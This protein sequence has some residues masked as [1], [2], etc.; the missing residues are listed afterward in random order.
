MYKGDKENFG[1][2]QLA[3]MEKRKNRSYIK[4]PD[5][6]KDNLQIGDML[7]GGILYNTYCSSCH[8]RDGKGDNSRFP[9]LAGSDWVT[10][11]PER[12]LDAILN[13]LQGEIKVNGQTWEGLMPAHAAILDDHAVASI[14]TYIRQNFG[15]NAG[16]ITSKDV[17]LVRNASNKK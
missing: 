16:S 14:A 12:L 11:E 9:T 6:V 13:G 7:A 2:A 8:Q 1:E 15:N 10:G 3:K 5:P 17:S 4:E